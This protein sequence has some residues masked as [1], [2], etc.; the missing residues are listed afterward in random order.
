MVCGNTTGKAS[1]ACRSAGGATVTTHS[2]SRR[3][4]SNKASIYEDTHWE[5]P[6]ETNPSKTYRVSQRKD[7]GQLVCSCPK[8]IFQRVPLEKKNHVNISNRYKLEWLPLPIRIVSP[9]PKLSFTECESPFRS[10]MIM[11]RSQR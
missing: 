5:F 3:R 4:E 6:S 2:T 10:M 1:Q 7:N 8:F 11:V 9:S